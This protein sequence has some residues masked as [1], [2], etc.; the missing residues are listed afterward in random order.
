[1]TT[2][3]K[4]NDNIVIN[5]ELQLIH[6]EYAILEC[7]D[8]THAFDNIDDSKDQYHINPLHSKFNAKDQCWE[9]YVTF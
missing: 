7:F 6:Y 4:Y 8:N 3:K 2:T 1:M 9:R 5:L